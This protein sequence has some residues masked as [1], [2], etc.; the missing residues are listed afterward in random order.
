MHPLTLDHLLLLATIES[1]ILTGIDAAPSDAL[2]AAWLCSMPAEIAQ[3]TLE[4][5]GSMR[6]AFETWGAQ[7]GSAANPADSM[8]SESGKL[9]DY[10]TYYLRAPRRW[11]SD[12]K[13]AGVK[14]PWMIFLR[15][16]LRRHLACSRAE[17]GQM[18]ACVAFAHY[19]AI[20]E[21]NGD[22][23][24]MSERDVAESD[25]INAEGAP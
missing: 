2:L 19:A 18:P 12:R 5:S 14:T 6:A 8:L 23:D 16:E 1:P 9:R 10:M 13:D 3:T 25:R 17:A 24:L 7:W 22:K 20:A 11:G 15:T 21:A 4:R